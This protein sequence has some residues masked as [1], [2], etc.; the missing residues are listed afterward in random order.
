M[1]SNTEYF[2]G[3]GLHLNGLGKEAICNQIVLTTEKI[4]QF[5][6]DKPTSMDWKSPSGQY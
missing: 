6:E 5:K 1:D 2:T 4:L 3:H